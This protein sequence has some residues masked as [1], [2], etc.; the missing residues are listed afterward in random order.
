[1]RREPIRFSWR[2]T[3]HSLMLAPCLLSGLPAAAALGGSIV[4]HVLCLHPQTFRIS[5][6]LCRHSLYSTSISSCSCCTRIIPGTYFNEQHLYIFTSYSYNMQDMLLYSSNTIQQQ[7]RT[8]KKKESISMVGRVC[9]STYIPVLGTE[10][11]WTR[12]YN[13]FSFWKSSANPKSRPKGTRS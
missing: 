10:S 2:E 5:Q 1:M 6:N 13:P 8:P 11:P 7:C 9:A 3:T 4:T 12:Q